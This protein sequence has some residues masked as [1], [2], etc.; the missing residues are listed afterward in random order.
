MTPYY[1]ADRV[2]IYHGDVLEVLR[3]LPVGIAQ[4]CVTSPPYWGLRQYF[5]DGA[6]QIRHDL[7]PEKQAWLVAELERRGVKA[8]AT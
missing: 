5:F 6:S 3:E 7:T 2:K 4:T 1:E 8:K